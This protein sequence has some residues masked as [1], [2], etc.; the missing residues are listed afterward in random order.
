MELEAS[1]LNA[2]IPCRLAHGRALSDERIIA[3]VLAALHVIARPGDD[4]VRERFF[5]ATLPAALL[6]HARTRA[7]SHK[8]TLARELAEMRDRA[9]RGDANRKWISLALARL[10]NLS[11]LERAHQSLDL[12]VADLLSQNIGR[13]RRSRNATMS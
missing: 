7:R 11:A 8:R 2:G 6:D 1:L 13:V 5:G 10:R 3:Y 12:L 4:V 9:P